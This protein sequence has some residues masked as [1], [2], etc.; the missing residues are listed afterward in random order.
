MCEVHSFDPKW[1]QMYAAACAKWSEKAVCA[2]GP[3][4]QF[5]QNSPNSPSFLTIVLLRTNYMATND[6]PKTDPDLIAY[7]CL[8]GT[9]QVNLS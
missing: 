7:A 1:D 2:E 9:V 6:L 8:R 3:R 5:P 4:E